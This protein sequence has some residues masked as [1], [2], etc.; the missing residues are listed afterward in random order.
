MVNNQAAGF[1][2]QL[3]I[4]LVA[5]QI[6]L[7]FAGEVVIAE[8][9]KR[10]QDA[11][12]SL[13]FGSQGEELKKLRAILGAEA[14]WSALV[15]MIVISSGNMEGGSNRQA[16]VEVKCSLA[17]GFLCLNGHLIMWNIECNV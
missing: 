1:K 17:E 11:L 7:L 16:G 3:E 15:T 12:V 9:L 14:T 8:Y 5:M 2:M 10:Y 6:H 4:S 13:E